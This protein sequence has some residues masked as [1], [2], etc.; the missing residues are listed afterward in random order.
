MFNQTT[1]QPI[2]HQKILPIKRCIHE[3]ID[4]FI[5]TV[6]ITVSHVSI[7]VIIV[8]YYLVFNYLL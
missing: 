7:I 4:P 1:S 6:N 3:D 2:L 8:Y 5:K